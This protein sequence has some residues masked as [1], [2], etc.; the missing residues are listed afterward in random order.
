MVSYLKSKKGELL[1][2]LLMLWYATFYFIEARGLP[3]PSV[4]LLLVKPVYIILSVSVLLFFVLSFLDFRKSNASSS[5]SE[6]E[7]H[8]KKETICF[9]IFT[10]LY[11]FGIEWLGFVVA[12]WLYMTILL[13]VFM[14]KSWSLVSLMP[15]LTV[16]FIYG[17]FDVWLNIP[18][19]AGWFI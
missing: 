10:I 4:N 11:V 8:E 19:P 12:T 15:V 17:V 3:R 9:L 2:P 16:A 13:M 14:K 18:L 6:I 7:R 5:D 1:V